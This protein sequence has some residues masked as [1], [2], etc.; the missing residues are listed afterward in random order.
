[1]SVEEQTM[2]RPILKV[3]RIAS[4]SNGHL[5]LVSIS[6]INPSLLSRHKSDT[7]PNRIGKHHFC[8]DG[9]AMPTIP[10]LQ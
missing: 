1:M 10:R 9:R 8:M 5:R 4:P 6:Q 3:S 2:Q 7:L